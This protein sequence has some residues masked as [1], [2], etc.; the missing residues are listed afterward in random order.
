MPCWPTACPAAPASSTPYEWHAQHLGRWKVLAAKLSSVVARSHDSF[1]RHPSASPGPTWWCA[2]TSTRSPAASAAASSELS[3][4]QVSIC[5]VI[6][7]VFQ[8]ITVHIAGTDHWECTTA[9]SPHLCCSTPSIPVVHVRLRCADW[10]AIQETL[11]L[12]AQQ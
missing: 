6:W 12:D 1:P 8:T 10:V 5:S 4:L 3:H 7:L 11:R 2:A 9:H